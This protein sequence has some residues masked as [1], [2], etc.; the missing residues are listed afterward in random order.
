[1][2]VG[3][4]VGA[5][6]FG[7]P[8]VIMRS[9]F[10]IGLWH[11]LVIALL[12]IITMLYLG[13]VTL[14][15]KYNH[16]MTGYA[17]K[18]LGRKGKL[19]MLFAMCFGIYSAILAYLIGV[20]ESLSFLFVG[21]AGGSLYMGIAFWI[22]MSFLSY[23]G[24]KAL[25]KGEFIGV[26][27]VVI[28]IISMAV[29]FFN[30]IDLGNLNYNN[31]GGLRDYFVPFGVILFAFLGY[32]TIPE[33][34]KLLGKKKLGM[35]KSIIGAVVISAIIYIVF[36]IIVIGFKGQDTPQIATIA[37]GGP[38][39][40]LGIFTMFTSY[41]ALSI[42]LIDILQLDFNKSKHRAWFYTVLV[43]L[44]LFVLLHFTNSVSFT[45]VLGIGGVISGGLTGILILLMAYNAKFLG[46]RKP[47]YSLPISKI[48][49]FLISLIFVA[50][51]V[52][53][54]IGGF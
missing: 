41:L 26:S 27:A 39:I 45:K 47:E 17:E 18:Y 5:G 20:G 36:T 50:G 22:V 9:S 32:T 25:E 15:T 6:I 37:L 44:G 52:V 29:F 42:S 34:N 31:I 43:P 8:Y 30:K 54:L 46:D 53:E 28:L 19:L 51:T 49:I 16:Q 3:T 12:M 40:L 21:N 38:F 4:I 13:E 11:I 10:S 24:L 7:I 2:L 1:M 14:R 33:V 48:I 23:F 35:K